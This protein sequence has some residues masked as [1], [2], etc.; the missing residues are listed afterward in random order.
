M[1]TFFGA[2]FCFAFGLLICRSSAEETI[3]WRPASSS[4]AKTASAGAAADPIPVLLSDPVPLSQ[5]SYSGDDSTP[6][7]FRPVTV[8]GKSTDDET[9]Q[10]RPL[11]PGAQAPPNISGSPQVPMIPMAPGQVAPP[12][13]RIIQSPMD[14][15]LIPIEPTQVPGG[16]VVVP[17]GVM[18][19]PRPSC[20]CGGGGMG[21]GTIM[22]DGTTIIDD[23]SG[24]CCNGGCTVDGC[25][26]CGT[27]GPFGTFGAGL[28]LG[29]LDWLK[30]HL[31][32]GWLH[33]GCCTDGCSDGGFMD[34]CCT[35]SCGSGFCPD[36]CCLDGCVM[37][38]CFDGCCYNG[39]R[40][41][42]WFTSEYLLWRF[43]QPGLPALVTAGAAG[44]PL[45][46]NPGLTTGPALG[47][48]G[49]TT[50]IGGDSFENNIHSGMRFGFGFWIPRFNDQLGVDVS[51]LYFPQTTSTQSAGP[52]AIVGRPFTD[53]TPGATPFQNTEAVNGFNGTTGT[54]NVSLTQRIWGLDANLRYKLYC[55]PNLRIDLLAGYR[56]F[57]LEEGVSINENLNFAGGSNSINDNYNVNNAF[58]GG[59]IGVDAE[60][61]FLPRWTLGSQVKLAMG[62]DHQ[63]VGIS[64][65]QSNPFIGVA[66][67]PAGVGFFATNS[68]IG[69]YSRNQF[70]VLPEANVKLGLDITKN[71]RIFVG[72][73][74]LYMSNAVRAGSAID[75]TINQ[76]NLF[77][78]TGGNPARPSF[79]FSNS[80][81]LAQ[82]ANIGLDIHY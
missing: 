35:G 62:V 56:N 76:N 7:Q 82:G 13:G 55:C 21:G 58:N 20:N 54:V 19:M 57:N 42:M 43:S 39:N 6:F 29:V 11:P 33:G 2:G 41:H 8:R 65:S 74:V 45:A 77:G 5:T 34:G 36:N 28:H 32:L 78:G 81:F 59:Q 38:G 53:V 40:N 70:S 4:S 64:G 63:S 69:N 15:Q 75:T 3:Q 66:N 37:P 51:V 73:N 10:P 44:T 18:V 27:C 47:Q 9:L 52:G 49:T 46:A 25:G 22:S 71:V 79:A 80:S 26:S 61:R 68:N 67:A 16:S 12:G 1:R 60:W 14:D 30:M 48:P 17:D 50:L 31:P 72:Y 23:G 24:S